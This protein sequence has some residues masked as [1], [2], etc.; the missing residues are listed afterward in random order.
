MRSKW[1]VALFLIFLAGFSRGAEGTN[2]LW[3]EEQIDSIREIQVR[4]MG[5][6]ISEYGKTARTSAMASVCENANS[7]I[8]ET[9]LSEVYEFASELAVSRMMADNSLSIA[10][11]EEIVRMAQLMGSSLYTNFLTGY[12]IGYREALALTLGLDSG[13]ID[14]AYLKNVYCVISNAAIVEILGDS[15][16]DRKN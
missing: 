11:I 6:V 2:F 16:N 10:P 1:A 14:V 5:D 8:L 7:Q 4:L 3:S 12:E 15:N 9:M 13:V